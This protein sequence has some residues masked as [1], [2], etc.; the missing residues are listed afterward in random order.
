ML[1]P[2][3]GGRGRRSPF[4]WG[5]KV[6]GD[7][8]GWR[9]WGLSWV[10]NP[11]LMSVSGLCSGEYGTFPVSVGS[12]IVG[13]GSFRW[14]GRGAEIKDWVRMVCVCVPGFDG[15][16]SMWGWGGGVRFVGAGVVVML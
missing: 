13:W 12:L 16:F 9:G 2:D 8:S 15:V 10:L 3:P 11:L 1:V 7:F 6:M 4:P 14:W 5:G